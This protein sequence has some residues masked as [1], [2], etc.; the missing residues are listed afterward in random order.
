MNTDDNRLNLLAP[1]A[2]K[3]KLDSLHREVQD[4]AGRPLTRRQALGLG[5]M[6]MLAAACGSTA[7][8]QSGSSPAG[9]ANP[10]AGKSL[11]N[12]LEIY[13][14]SEYDDPSTFAKFK[15]LP[16]ETKAGLALHETFYSSNDELLAKLH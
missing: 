13:N 7:T 15:K 5:G 16:A 12:H 11:E 1:G 9:S 10:L 4:T 14:W 2:M 8:R 6:A 3:P